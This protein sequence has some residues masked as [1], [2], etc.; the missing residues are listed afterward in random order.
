[1]GNYTLSVTERFVPITYRFAE[2]E[3]LKGIALD[4]LAHTR[5]VHIL[6]DLVSSV[7]VPSWAC[8]SGPTVQS[9]K[10][11]VV[12]KSITDWVKA[13]SLHFTCISLA[14]HLH[15]CFAGNQ[16][17]GSH[18]TGS[19]AENAKSYVPGTDA[20]RESRYEQG[21]DTGRDTGRDSSYTGTGS[22][23]Q[24][25]GSH[26]TGSTAENAKSYIPGTDAN[27]ESRYE[28]GRDTGR[29]TGRDSSYTGTGSG[30]QGYGNQGSGN[31]RH[32]S[33]NSGSNTGGRGVASYVPGTE[34]NRESRAE[35]GQ[36]PNRYTGSGSGSQGYGSSNTSSGE[37]HSHIPCAPC[38]AVSS[39][40]FQ[41]SA[42]FGKYQ[43]DIA[44]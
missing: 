11:S 21:R 10:V 18:N 3:N 39:S 7:W 37:E 23:N 20:N 14:F 9:L 27:R 8:P 41:G 1:M 15:L 43:F 34:A 29:D 40:V 4:G 2:H 33:G 12:T 19:T 25:Y 5:F 30:N 38:T 31:Q 35:H 32:G 16:S 22:G 36:D 17:Y 26:N 13:A 28:Q 44:V 24:S 42:T 6:K